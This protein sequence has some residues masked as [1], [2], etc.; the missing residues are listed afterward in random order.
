MDIQAMRAKRDKL[1]EQIKTAKADARRAEREAA[2]AKEK[3]ENEAHFARMFEEIGQP[4]AGLNAEQ[5]SIVYAQAW[6]HG[7]AC[8]YSEVENYYGDFAEMARKL[9]EAK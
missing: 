6:E 4:L 3:A 1:D 7:H 8:G 9:I 5:H 2:R